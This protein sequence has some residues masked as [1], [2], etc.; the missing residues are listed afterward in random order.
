MCP[1]QPFNTRGIHP[2]KE[3]MHS[4]QDVFFVVRKCAPSMRRGRELKCYIHTDIQT[5][6]H[7]EPPTKRVLEEHSLLKNSVPGEC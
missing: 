2:P 4:K 5:D 6:I 7:T 3:K 1:S